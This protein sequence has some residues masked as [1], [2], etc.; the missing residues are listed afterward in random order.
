VLFVIADAVRDGLIGVNTLTG[1][2]AGAVAGF[3]VSELS[4]QAARR[5]TLVRRFLQSRSSLLI[6]NGK[7]VASALFRAS[8]SLPELRQIARGEGFEDLGEVQTAILEKN[9]V[10]TL[11]GRS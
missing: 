11:L 4:G 6:D 1:A 5:S 8:I 2:L 10:V 7:P 9:G 3:G